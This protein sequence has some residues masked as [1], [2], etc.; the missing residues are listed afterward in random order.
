M[1]R[2]KSCLGFAAGWLLLLAAGLATVALFIEPLIHHRYDDH[3]AGEYFGRIHG[4][5]DAYAHGVASMAF[6]A[7][8]QRT[9]RCSAPRTYTYETI[10]FE[11]WRDE[12]GETAGV[13][14]V[15]AMRIEHDGKSESL[16]KEVFQE[17]LAGS[18]PLD[19]NNQA[20]FDDV[21]DLFRSAGAGDFPRPM[22]HYYQLGDEEAGVVCSFAHWSLGRRAPHTFI[23][24]GL[25]WLAALLAR[26]RRL[27]IPRPAHRQVG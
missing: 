22:H 6:R 26:L 11:L 23:I 7:E 12:A 16:T 20:A 18:S 5:L 10:S 8:S 25:I 14:H 21:F 4:R 2:L 1:R 13:I 17:L 3:G 24:W 19:A 27:A 15:P 9:W